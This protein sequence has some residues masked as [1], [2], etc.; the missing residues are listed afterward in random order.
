[1]AKEKLILDIRYCESD[2]DNISGNSLPGRPGQIFNF[3]ESSSYIGARIARKLRENSFVTGSFDHVYIN[4]T[5]VLPAGEFR[6]SPRET[7]ARL[8]YV[9]Y[10]AS[11]AEFD[12]LSEA[13]KES[14]VVS[15]T[16]SVLRLL[17]SPEPTQLAIIDNVEKLVE[18]HESELEITHK[19]K[20]TKSYKVTITY[21]IC[22]NGDQSVGIVE[23]VDKQTGNTSRAQFVKLMHYEDIFALVSGISVSSGVICLKPRASFKAS[24][25]VEKYK[26]PIEIPIAE[27]G[28]E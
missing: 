10:G 13:Q 1:M 15:T 12:N 17:A 24:L 18:L 11:P 27:I 25:Y 21:K 23:Y 14:F 20:D 9:D 22:P 7:Q 6:I 28:P 2:F 26:V 5:T 3:P 16:F 19:T 4:F 8:K